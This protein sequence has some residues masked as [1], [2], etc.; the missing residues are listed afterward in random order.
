MV[1]VCIPIFSILV[2]IGIHKYTRI[3]TGDWGSILGREIPNSLKQAL[4]Y[5]FFYRGYCIR[6]KIY[7]NYVRNVVNL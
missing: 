6:M 1:M 5:L 4:L 7:T 2:Y 3:H